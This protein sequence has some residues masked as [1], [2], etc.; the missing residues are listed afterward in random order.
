MKGSSKGSHTGDQEAEAGL[1]GGN[2]LSFILNCKLWRA[3]DCLCLSLCPMC[4]WHLA[5]VL[6]T[7]LHKYLPNA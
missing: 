6:G 1:L 3:W 7:A 2:L 4:A 5:R